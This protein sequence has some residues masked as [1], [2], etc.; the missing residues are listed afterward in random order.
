M[1]EDISHDIPF[2]FVLVFLLGMYIAVEWN[3]LLGIVIGFVSIATLALFNRRA[4]PF[5]VLF[6]VLCI[7]SF[8][9]RQ[10]HMPPV[11]GRFSG[12]VMKVRKGER[13]A[14]E[15]KGKK[16]SYYAIASPVY[17]NILPYDEVFFKGRFRSIRFV[18]DKGF[19]EY[20]IS[21]GIDYYGYV[22]SIEPIARRSFMSMI[23]DVKLR[24]E[25]EFRYFLPRRDFVFLASAVF[26]D[27]AE[28]ASIKAPFVNTQTA[29]IMVVSGL[30]IGFVFGV[31]YV[32]FYFLIGRLECFYERY[33]LGIVASLLSFIPVSVYFVMS[34]MNIPSLRAFLFVAIFIVSL[35]LG[36]ER[37]AYNVLFFVA[38]LFVVSSDFRVLHSASFVLSFAMSFFAIFL[39]IFVS[40]IGGSKL[41][42]YVLFILLMSIFAVPLSAYYFGRVS[43]FS[44][45]VNSVV[46]PYFG[47]VVIPCTF[48]SMI[49]ATMGV[50]GLEVVVFKALHI[51]LCPLF[52]VVDLFSGI[53]GLSIHPSGIGMLIVYACMLALV[54]LLRVTVTG[55]R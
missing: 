29:H 16:Y 46:V 52:Y 2:L 49:I 35:V 5:A 11:S 39:S 7:P 18:D 34:G 50:Y 33:R 15:I 22:S 12:M 48:L 28:K 13:I 14:F 10:G 51:V 31:F 23:E 37:M 27:T 6:L 44:P 1:I 41:L 8:T 9:S 20:L 30:H 40:S 53:G 55:S 21:R 43:L 3:I 38:L 47:F 54:Y 24:L 42:R 19:R 36:F 4:L 45:F 17:D 25:R 26:G 32:L